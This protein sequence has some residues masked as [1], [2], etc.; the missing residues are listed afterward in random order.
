MVE[1]HDCRH[2]YFDLSFYIYIFCRCDICVSLVRVIQE[3]VCACWEK[4]MDGWMDGCDSGTM[5]DL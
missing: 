4:W 5:G 3:C 1:I 2:P